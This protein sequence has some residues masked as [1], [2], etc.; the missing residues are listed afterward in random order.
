MLWT[1]EEYKAF[2][3]VFNGMVNEWHSEEQD[4]DIKMSEFDFILET[5]DV[6]QNGRR[7]N[8]YFGWLDA[9]QGY[10]KYKPLMT[11]MG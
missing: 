7:R 1:E 9:L 4:T 2:A 3:N 11:T 8:E 5:G 6:S 10:N